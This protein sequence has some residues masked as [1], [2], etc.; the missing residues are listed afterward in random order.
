MKIMTHPILFAQLGMD[1][2]G[3]F[4]FGSGQRK[5]LIVAVKYFTN[6]AQIEPVAIITEHRMEAFV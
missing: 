2:L 3:L 1:I 6:L 5:F 4:P